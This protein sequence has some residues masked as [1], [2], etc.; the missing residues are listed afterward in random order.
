MGWR[1]APPDGVL[2][3]C[4]PASLATGS[5][6]PGSPASWSRR[7]GTAARHSGSGTGEPRIAGAVAETKTQACDL[8]RHTSSWSEY[9]KEFAHMVLQRPSPLP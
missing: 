8:A 1:P 3:R 4:T 9:W 2:L 6:Q 5:P 7:R